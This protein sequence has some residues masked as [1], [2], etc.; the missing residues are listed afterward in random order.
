MD[1]R[2]DPRISNMRP[3][4]LADDNEWSGQLQALQLDEDIR[5]IESQ[6][7]LAGGPGPQVDTSWIK[8][9]WTRW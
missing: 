5:W 9:E 3:A 6:W 1:L 8:L 2:P 4:W 7:E